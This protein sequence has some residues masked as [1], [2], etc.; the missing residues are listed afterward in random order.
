MLSQIACACVAIVFRDGKSRPRV[1][2][3]YPS[4]LRGDPDSGALELVRGLLPKASEGRHRY[5]VRTRAAGMLSCSCCSNTVVSCYISMF[6]NRSIELATAPARKLKSADLDAKRLQRPGGPGV[7]GR[8]G[9]EAQAAT[10]GRR[11]RDAQAPARR[12]TVIAKRR[13]AWPRTLRRASVI[14]LCSFLLSLRP[15]LR[16]GGSQAQ[17][18][19]QREAVGSRGIRG[20]AVRDS[21]RM[22][23]AHIGGLRVYVQARSISVSPYTDTKDPYDSVLV[24][25]T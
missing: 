2:C 15:L 5:D 17:A 25:S 23:N 7:W 24:S 11:A 14:G 18:D 16:G 10:K 12:P 9:A 3:N 6:R 4:R 22:A 19:R 8:R 21:S 13:H 20:A 1:V